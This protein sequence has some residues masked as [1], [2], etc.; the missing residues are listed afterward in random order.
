MQKVFGVWG[1][2]THKQF[3]GIRV[4]NI[5]L[6]EGYYENGRGVI[7]PQGGLCKSHLNI[8]EYTEWPRKVS[9]YQ[10]IKKSY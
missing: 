2:Q 1:R 8:E 3:G 10:I 9:H 7:Y 6:A 4:K 5:E